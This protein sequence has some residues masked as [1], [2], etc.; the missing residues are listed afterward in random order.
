[1]RLLLSTSLTHSNESI[2]KSF[3]SPLNVRRN[4]LVQSFIR[5]ILNNHI[6]YIHHITYTQELHQVFCTKLNNLSPQIRV[7]IHVT[8]LN[9]CDIHIL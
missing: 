9:V 7:E 4:I 1:M 3:F 2:L 5:I 6:V 8:M